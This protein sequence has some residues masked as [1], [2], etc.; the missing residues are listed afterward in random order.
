M[1]TMWM[2]PMPSAAIQSINKQQAAE[3]ESS[4]KPPRK[5]LRLRLLFRSKRV[6][7]YSS[8]HAARCGN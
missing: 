4:N 6:L 5:A 7:I 3:V 2:V 8:S 1:M